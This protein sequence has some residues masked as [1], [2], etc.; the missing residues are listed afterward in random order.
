MGVNRLEYI[1]ELCKVHGKVSPSKDEIPQSTIST[2]LKKFVLSLEDA[3]ITKP[4]K[5][6]EDNGNK[7]K[8]KSD[9]K[10]Q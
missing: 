6:S 4:K 10:G 5:S 7:Q 8:G 1:A 3:P 9:K 2:D